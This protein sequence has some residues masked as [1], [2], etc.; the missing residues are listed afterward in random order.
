MT[1]RV[2]SVL[3]AATAALVVLACSP[4]RA[5][6]TTFESG[7]VRPLALSPDG[8]RLFAVNTPDGTLE[9]FSVG[10]G[11]LTRVGSVPVGLEPV[12]VAART[13]G[14]VWVVNHLSDSISI[15]DV[16]ASPPA[17]VRT[18]LVG[19]EPRD[20][21][22]AGTGGNRAFI[23][24]AH[25]GQ[26]R[27]D[28]SIVGVVGAGDPQLTT[29][30]VPR[31][32][33]WVFDATNL[34]AT[35]GGTPITIVQLFGD[36][37]RA[38]AVAPGGGTVYAGVFHSGNQ[39]TTVTEGVVCNGPPTTPCTIF[40]TTYPGG[41]PLPKTNFQL[42]QGPETG[43]IVK[44]D[45]GSGQWRDQLGR[46][47]NNAVKFSL[48][49]K[50]VFAISA[51][52]NPPVET[53]F[54]THVGTVLFNMAV[55]PVSGKVYVT[56]T[57]ARNEVRFEGPGTFGG[58]TVRGHLAESRVTVLSGAT[59]TPRHLN[60][61]I[62]YST[63]PTPADGTKEKSL[64]TP[65]GLAVS[66]D[67]GTLYV[68]A[69]GSSKVGIFS[70][71]AIENDTFVP[72][73]ADHVTLSGGGPSGL[74]L[75]EANQRLYVLTRFDNAI[76]VV[77]TTT[78]LQVA[79]IPVHNAE[80][81]SV[82]GGRPFLYDAA[83]TSSNGEAAC[84]SCHIFGD[85]DSLG[86]DLGNPDDTVVSTQ[87]NPIR[88]GDPFGTAFVG[89]HPMKGPMTTQSLRG[90]ANH[91]PMHW[92]GD[93][94]GAF[95]E[96]NAQPDGGAFDEDLAFKAFNVAFGGLLGRGGPL[97]AGEMQSF[98][99]F[100]LQVTYPPN[101][102]RA[103]DNSLNGDQ[104]A[105][106]N[107]YF[108]PAA[109]DVFQTCNG[110]HVL[111]PGLGFFGSDGFS[112]FENEPQF[113]KIPHLR[114]MYQKV[115][116]FGMP[117]TA[118]LNAGDNG[119]KGDQ[120]RG[121]G[122]LHDG[123]V[124]TLLRFHNATVFNQTN[125]AGIPIPNPGG[126]PNGAAGDPLRRQVEAFMLA[127]DSNLAPI[128]GQQITLT[129]T[130][131]GVVGGRID[132]LIQ[133]AGAGECEVIVKGSLAGRQRGWRRVGASFQ[134]DRASE[135]TITDAALRAQA[136]VA[137]QQ[138]TYTCV[139]PGSGLRMGLDRDEDGFFDTD[140]VDAG[141]DP[142]DASSVPGP[143]TTTTSTTVTSTTTIAP[144]TT[145][146]LAFVLVQSTSLTLKDDNVA[147]VNPATRKVSFKSSTRF[148]PPA[149]RVVVPPRFSSGD[150]TVSG[151]SLT[152]YNSA[153]MTTDAV[154]VN[155][156]PVGPLAGQGWFAIGAGPSFKGYRYRGR[157][158]NGPIA[159]IVVKADS[160]SVRGGRANWGYT[161][162]E[163][164]QT[165]VAVRLQLG[166]TARWCADAPAKPAGNPPSTTLN[167]HVDRFVGQPKI[168]APFTCP[169][170]P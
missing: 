108:G 59:V 123:S 166:T 110:C 153:G 4:A 53:G 77:N 92:R 67:G 155:L 86:W 80:P 17:V 162:N 27:T 154:T 47:W 135:S 78:R 116:M 18:L 145:T 24:T 60:K 42:I 104:T 140:E 23:T 96:P 158:P 75:D 127:F 39:T 100:I 31:A 131:A 1:T 34:G 8:T 159:S 88:V 165:R 20:I 15:V 56:N 48:P 84:A 141:S 7:Q 157:D 44:F 124:D 11:S 142:A 12:A 139:P 111:N 132:L 125:P 167:D 138:R 151:G 40:S 30:G 69:F 6:F 113:V 63:V 148:D 57:D 70:T 33:V 68:A 83:F 98:T 89:F 52:A 81:A 136:A 90:M 120:V 41:L 43:L 16:A 107:F 117:R 82:V 85:F 97:T 129:S 50:D 36:T 10:G 73:A 114:N 126:F 103:L 71:S 105:G 152:V 119:A 109:S 128:V 13:N 25:R 146:T 2:P 91:G 79:H 37:P 130:N 55:N 76:S 133:R 28:P 72:N 93:R 58:S 21:V 61:H 149:F 163:S 32:D 106:R 9:I 46:N 150:P 169:P 26:Q 161:L 102:V 168:P 5:A 137:G 115:G 99:N 95:L 35:F 144:T 3:R 66:S 118:F 160:I 101:P 54:F 14:E 143:T 121:F 62:V 170:T 29:A 38:L 74:V 87:V 156:P 112:T 134:S 49:D 147:P 164:S 22:F 19:D 65:T 51:T 45:Q 122:F 94:T 64:A